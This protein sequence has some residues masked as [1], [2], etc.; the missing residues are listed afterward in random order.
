MLEHNIE[1]AEMAAHMQDEL[2]DMVGSRLSVSTGGGRLATYRVI[3][4]CACVAWDNEKCEY[5]GTCAGAYNSSSLGLR[6]H[7]KAMIDAATVC[8]YLNTYA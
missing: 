4:S 8:D 3:V 2:Q 5:V 7:G 6:G 1:F